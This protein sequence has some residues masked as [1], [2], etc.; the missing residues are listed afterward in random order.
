MLMKILSS[1]TYMILVFLGIKRSYV[2]FDQDLSLFLEAVDGR[3]SI[4]WSFITLTLEQD[5][6]SLNVG[7]IIYS[8]L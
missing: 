6:L 2:D 4:M 8:L 1:S 5:S 3:G 7:S